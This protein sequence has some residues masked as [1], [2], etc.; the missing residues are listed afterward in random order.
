MSFPATLRGDS[1]PSDTDSPA[2]K[3]LV[4]HVVSCLAYGDTNEF[5]ERINSRLDT[6]FDP[7]I[8]SK[9]FS[10]LPQGKITD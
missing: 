8:E 4:D 7:V 1:Y 9:N 6:R 10:D 5:F 2:V 3:S